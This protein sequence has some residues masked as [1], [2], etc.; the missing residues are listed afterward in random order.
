MTEQPNIKKL[1]LDWMIKRNY[2]DKRTNLRLLAERENIKI[3]RIAKKS[4][5]MY[6]ALE[7]GTSPV[8]PWLCDKKTAIK[9]YKSW[10]T[11]PPE[12]IDDVRWSL[13]ENI[14]YYD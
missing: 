10:N 6:S 11:E 7:C 9:Y 14:V 8:V 1:I 4:G 12:E 13:N 2:Q 3:N 5:E